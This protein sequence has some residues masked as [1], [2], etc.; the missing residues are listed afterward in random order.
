MMATIQSVI[1]NQE[2]IINKI[3]QK[4]IDYSSWL[5][6]THERKNYL[7]MARSN[8]V[9]YK[10]VLV[11]EQDAES[12]SEEL[13][14]K[15]LKIAKSLATQSNPGYLIFDFTML[16]KSY[17][18]FI[19]NVTYDR[20]GCSNRI[21]KGLSIGLAVWSN[22][23]V[24]VPLA[25]NNWHRKV[26]VPDS[27]K[28][29][30]ELAKEMILDLRQKIAFKKIL[31]DGAFSSLNMLS[32]CMNQE[33]DFAF[34]IARNRKIN[35]D[36]VIEQLQ[37]HPALHLRKNQKFKTVTGDYKGLKLY[38]TAE[39]RKTK[40][41]KSEVVFIVSNIPLSAKQTVKFYKKRNPVECSIR[42]KKQYIGL[43]DCQSTSAKKQSLHILAVMLAYAALSITKFYK[44]KK[45]PEEILNIIRRQ[46]TSS[47]A[48]EYLDLIET[49]MKF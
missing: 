41:G 33:F 46:K 44:K 36:G 22:D 34:R 35:V 45:C 4:A 40:D 19:E 3:E 39:K 1:K 24:T 5:I 25:F 13:K 12:C 10:D 31:M 2:K 26:D 38:F 21:E 27:Y 16:L 20:D 6:T 47:L 7:S 37:T 9:D 18:F 14:N 30:I 17:S 11:T 42:T 23:Q 48:C 32:F 43:L 15:L 8:N 49:I 28:S 29:K